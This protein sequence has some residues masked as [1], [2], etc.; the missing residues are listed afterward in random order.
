M[1]Y[2]QLTNIYCNACANEHN[3]PKD[4]NIGY[5]VC[6]ICRLSKPCYAATQDEIQSYRASMFG[7]KIA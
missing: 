4:R 1:T 3:L 6:V 2:R 5:G 7:R